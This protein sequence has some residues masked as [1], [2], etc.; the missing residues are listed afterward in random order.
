MDCR[1]MSPLGLLELFCKTIL[2]HVFQRYS[3]T[4]FFSGAGAETVRTDGCSSYRISTHFLIQTA[5]A[6]S[7][8]MLAMALYPDV[9]RKA[10][11]QID[12]V[13]GAGRLPTFADAPNLPYL[14]AMVMEVL[15]W[16]PIA[17]LG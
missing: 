15:R 2:Y 12:V 1:T 14:R 6:L 17:P 5:A 11:H 9:M 13:V 3:I 7:M 10:K 8:F 4:S 16:R